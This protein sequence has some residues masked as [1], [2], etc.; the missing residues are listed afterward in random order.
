V[1]SKTPIALR[2]T[3]SAAEQTDAANSLAALYPALAAEWEATRNGILVPEFT[4]PASNRKVWW[5][6]SK[7]QHL[8]QARVSSRTR[9]HGCP[10]CGR[11]ASGKARSIPG[12]GESLAEKFPEVA[13]DWHP[14]RNGDLTP[15][16]VGYASN[17]MVWW[18]CHVCGHE[19]QRQVCGRTQHRSSCPQCARTAQAVPKAGNSLAERCPEVAE[20][21]HLTRNGDLTPSDVSFSKKAKA[22]W[23]CSG[24]GHEWLAVIGNRVH[25]PGCPNCGRNGRRR[26]SRD[27]SGASDDGKQESRKKK[28]APTPAPLPGRSFAERFPEPA[29]DWH[30]TRNGELTADQVSCASNRRAWWLCSTCGHEWSAVINSRGQG[31]GC[32]DCKRRTIGQKNALPKPGHSFA[33][34]FPD[35]AAEWHSERNQPLTP[36]QVAAKSGRRVWWRCRTCEHEWEAP[37]YSRAN[38]FGC[39]ACAT[40]L[41]AVVNRAPKPSQSLAERDPEIA[42][43]WHP[44]LNG[45]LTASDVTGN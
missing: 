41:A 23:K 38:G 29:A 31:A 15:S 39:K 42:A 37:V 7:C 33:E 18:Q 24:C 13:A 44:T 4:A 5:V 40:R 1:A 32:P 21:W 34:R 3:M 30:P 11:R 17:K 16:D 43:Q 28:R 6:C 25:W 20:E 22:W 8:W 26:H 12:P 36:E 45:S 27:M 10:A 19:W 14:T 35:I 2:G 9:G